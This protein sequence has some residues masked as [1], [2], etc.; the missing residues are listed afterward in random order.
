[1]LEI[2]LKWH[3]IN[4]DVIY[5]SNNLINKVKLY[6]LKQYC[7]IFWKFEFAQM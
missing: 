4:V 6:L 5:K 3:D 2:G 1:M 7:M